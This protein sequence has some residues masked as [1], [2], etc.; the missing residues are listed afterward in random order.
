M[1]KAS[2]MSWKKSSGSFHRN[3][4]KG[5]GNEERAEGCAGWGMLF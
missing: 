2:F 4:A 1:F 3:D 5:I